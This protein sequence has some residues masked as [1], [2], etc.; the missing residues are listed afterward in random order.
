[1][2][3]SYYWFFRVYKLFYDPPGTP[4]EKKCVPC[5][6]ALSAGSGLLVPVSFY[7]VYKHRRGNLK[8]ILALGTAISAATFS[9]IMLKVALDNHT[10]N[11]RL[12]K[13]NLENI[14]KQRLEAS[15][16]LDKQ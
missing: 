6:L 16:Q 7:Q 12:T 2:Y 1:M 5:K 8:G 4:K 15:G 10:T 9:V 3:D 11:K 13:E 14:R